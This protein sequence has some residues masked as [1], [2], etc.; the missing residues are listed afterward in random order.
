MSPRSDPYRSSQ[1]LGA[2]ARQTEARAL[3][4]TAR[5]LADAQ[6]NMED[7]SAYRAALRLNW[8]LWT[9]FQADVSATENPLPE[10]IKQ[11]ILNLSVFID[12]H[13]VDALTDPEGRKLKVLIDINR[14]IASGLMA[15]PPD[16]GDTPPAPSQP[17]VGGMA[18]GG[19]VVA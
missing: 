15:N 19:D 2:G 18:G 17:P 11:N 7:I 16:A 10:D 12:K 14:N 8:R 4:E 5:A 9:I 6:E 1:K 3:M 13:T